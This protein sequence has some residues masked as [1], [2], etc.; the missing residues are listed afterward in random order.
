[1]RTRN[2]NR[3]VIGKGKGEAIGYE[4]DRGTRVKG[5]G[6]GGGT[7]GTEKEPYRTREEELVALWPK[8]CRA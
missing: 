6:S 2:K 5:R 1:M 3:G 7:E 8:S 4:D